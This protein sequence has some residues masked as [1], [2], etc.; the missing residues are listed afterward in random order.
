[1]KRVS[2]S[3]S[4][5]DG[6]LIPAGHSGRDRSSRLDTVIRARPVF[7]VQLVMRDGR[8]FELILAWEAKSIRS[9]TMAVDSSNDCGQGCP[10]WALRALQSPPVANRATPGNAKGVI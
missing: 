5:Y 10:P 3:R 7:S 4:H 2:V 6:H 8:R 9:E 1:M